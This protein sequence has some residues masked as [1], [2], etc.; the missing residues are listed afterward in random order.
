LNGHKKHSHVNCYQ[1]QR[2]FHDKPPS[3]EARTT[4]RSS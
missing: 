4:K 2:R 3:E 1:S